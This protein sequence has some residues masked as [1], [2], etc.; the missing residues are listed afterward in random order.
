MSEEENAVV[1]APANDGVDEAKA[2]FG[3]GQGETQAGV[4]NK[5]E[6]KARVD[7]GVPEG[8]YDLK[9]PEGVEADGELAAALSGEFK[10]LGLS[11]AQAQ[12]LVDKYIEAQT[13]RMESQGEKWGETVSGWIDEA[14]RDQEIGGARWDETVSA[15][16][17]A[18]STFGTPA[19]RDY[20][21][22]S[23][24]GNHPEIIRFMA[25]VGSLLGEDRLAGGG[26]VG[27]G[28]PTEAAHILFGNDVKQ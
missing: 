6:D 7:A 5:G 8:D 17:L 21:N 19:L 23:G 4:E 13:K 18:V 10:E 1:Q 27:A 26:A 9:M 2:L 16:R 25:K 22:A 24:G 11:N 20:L 15:G 3:G 14:K 28:K 12:R